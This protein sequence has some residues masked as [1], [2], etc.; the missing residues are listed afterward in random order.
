MLTCTFTEYILQLR[1]SIKR[2]KGDDIVLDNQF[3]DSISFWQHAY[4]KAQ[5]EQTKLL[6]TIY[7][8]EQRNN[9]LLA[10]TSVNSNV[11]MESQNSKKRKSIGA[12][13]AGDMKDSAESKKRCRGQP[14]THRFPAT[15]KSKR[16]G[17]DQ[18]E[19]ETEREPLIQFN[20]CY[21]TNCML[22]VSLLRSLYA[23]QRALQNRRSSS[24]LA[25]HAVTLCK[26]AEQELLTAI[27]V[28]NGMGNNSNSE[29][30]RKPSLTTLIKG[31]ELA[32]NLVHR[33]LHKITCA[34]DGTQCKGQVTYYIVCF[35]ESTLTALTQHCAGESKMAASG[36]LNERAVPGQK[37]SQRTQRDGTQ[38]S[39]EK[40]ETAQS[41]S[42]L[43]CTMALSLDLAR[44]EE[45]EIIEGF[46]FVALNRAGKLLAF[47]TFSNWFSSPNDCPRPNPPEGLAAITPENLTIE[48]AQL[49][50]KCLF[51]FLNKVLGRDSEISTLQTELLQPIKERLQKSLLQAVFGDNDPFFKEG[52]TR[53]ATPPPQSCDWQQL[54]ELEVSEWFVQGL[55]RLVGWDMLSSL[56]SEH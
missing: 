12:G 22:A 45:K 9:T 14:Q 1:A 43:L 21:P 18:E 31:M 15:S 27:I 54:D 37:A 33:T 26:E 46:L 29:N 11:E 17:A 34:K 7:E 38:S 19:V 13:P 25:I 2:R 16:V 49:E 32:F 8:L 42:D 40:Q 44:P 20:S 51:N 23:M 4:E 52:L 35:F 28:S 30:A 47:F 6:D 5:A 53:P 56:V 24:I 50:A 10:K 39:N 36:N 48:N 41:L 3:F 55:W